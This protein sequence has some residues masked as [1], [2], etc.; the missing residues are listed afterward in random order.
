MQYFIMKIDYFSYLAAMMHFPILP[1]LLSPKGRI[2]KSS[3]VMNLWKHNH[4]PPILSQC[5]PFRESHDC[6]S[7]NPV[8]NPPEAVAGS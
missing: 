2:A 6:D 5:M 1:V 7:Y 8:L 4:R 3:Q